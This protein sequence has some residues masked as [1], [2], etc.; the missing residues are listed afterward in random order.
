MQEFES[1][2]TAAAVEDAAI[3]HLV[4]RF[5]TTLPFENWSYISSYCIIC[6]NAERNDNKSTIALTARRPPIPRTCPADLV[7]FTI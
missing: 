7:I 5:H 6:L 4:C 1:S 2:W 3:L